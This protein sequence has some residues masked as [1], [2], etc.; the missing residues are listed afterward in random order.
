LSIL[1]HLLALAVLAAT[2][3]AAGSLFKLEG[4]AVRIALGLALL[5]HLGFLLAFVS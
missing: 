2:A 5:A 1:A 4:H 3:W